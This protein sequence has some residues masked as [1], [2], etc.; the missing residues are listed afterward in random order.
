MKNKLTKK[1]PSKTVQPRDTV[2]EQTLADMIELLEQSRQTAARAVN[3]VMTATYWEMGRRIVEIEQGGT[4]RANYGEAL[5]KHLAADL[6]ARFGRGFSERNLDQMR[7]FYTKWQISQTLSAKFDAGEVARRFPL[8]WSHYVRLLAVRDD[9][10]R[11]F[12]E[13]E[14][15][16]GGWSVRQLERQINSQFY[17]RALLSKNKVAMLTKGVKTKPEDTITPEEEIKSPFVLEFLGLKD[18]YSES[19]LEAALIEHLETFLL[20]LGGDF[21]FVGRQKRLRIDDEWFRIDLLFYHRRLRCLIIIELK[22]NQLTAADVGQV[23][24]YCNYAHKHWMLPDENPP[25]GLILS[26]GKGAAVAEYALGGLQNKILASDYLTALPDKA[27]LEQEL[28]KTRALLEARRTRK[29]K[30][31][32]R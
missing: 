12:Y 3:A 22:L 16:R 5:L 17:E 18:E 15:L 27:L 10:A 14:S 29:P 2:Y 9:N 7:L 30:T 4:R 1:L 8:S 13:A 19:E 28:Q 23:N 31:K 11:V 21:T 25:V 26:A 32:A 24:M 20:E 6:S